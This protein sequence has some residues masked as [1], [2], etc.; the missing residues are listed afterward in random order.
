M[1]IL[2]T[3]AW[4][5]AFALCAIAA[6]RTAPLAAPVPSSVVDFASPAAII[7]LKDKLTPYHAPGA[8]ETDGSRWYMLTALN[9]S[10]R[11][12]TRIFV[13]GQPPNAIMRFWPLPARPSVLQV[14]ASDSQVIVEEAR[15]HGRHVYRVTIPPAST[16]T[17]AVRLA[18]A[19]T[20]PSVL[21]WTEPAIVAH[22]RQLAVFVA[23]VA[24]MIAAA[25][26]IMLGLAVMTGHAAPFW[27]ALLL[28]AIF[29][30]R[31]AVTGTFDAGW[32]TRGG[33]FGLEVALAGL[34]FVVGLRLTDFIVPIET[35]WPGRRA[36]FSRGL[37]ALTI[38]SILS[39]LGVP[40]AM[41]L[42]DAMIVLGSIGVT[43][44]F[45][46]CGRRGNQ[47]ARV[48]APSAGVF[49]LVALG[50]TAVAFG[51]FA[52][53][54][55]APAIVGGFMAAGAV[56]LALAVA[57]GE[58]IAIL[59]ASRYGLERE[60]TPRPP[61]DTGTTDLKAIG[62]SHQGVF[63]LDFLAETVRLS[64]EAAM[65]TGISAMPLILPHATWIERIHPDD[66][67]TYREAIDDYRSHPGIAFRIEF[68]ALNDA[69]RHVWFELRAT[70]LGEGIRAER[71]LGLIADVTSRKEAD[72]SPVERETRDVLTGLGNRAALVDTLERLGA[73]LSSTIVAL[74]DMDRFKTVH[75][76]LGDQ[77]S[78]AVLAGMAQRLVHHF[79]KAAEIFRGGGDTFT[80]VFS[81]NGLTTAAIGGDLM[82]A[83]AA[84]FE[85]G[86]RNVFVTA[87]AGLAA[88]KDARD[89]FELLKNAELALLQAKRQGGACA[90]SYTPALESTAPGDAVALEADLRQAL[91]QQ[92]LDVYYQPIVRLSDGTLAGFEAL[93]RWHHPEKGLIEPSNFIAHSEQTGL[94]KAIGKLALERTAEDLAQWQRFFPLEPPLFASVNLS[95]RQL[96]DAEFE[97]ELKQVMNTHKIRPGTLKLEITESAVATGSDT[98]KIL[99]RLRKAGASLAIDDFGT[100]VSNFQQLKEIPFD[101]VKLDRSFLGRHG[102]THQDAEG[103]VILGSIVNLAHDLERDVVIEGVETQD[104]ADWLRGIGAEYGQG[105]YF[106]AP[107]PRTEALDFIARHYRIE[108]GQA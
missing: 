1:S 30:L 108:T 47:A 2:R 25:M 6:W 62:A 84:P 23:A 32:V 107:L 17:L 41:I 90:R 39:Y 91:D 81:G 98:S 40:G 87:S 44:Y 54:Q 63:E 21:A 49:A 51:M 57:A 43:L 72:S 37:I 89:P 22:N 16:V 93:M 60:E 24:G 92:Q 48:A 52:N 18:N 76:S 75:A 4:T 12:A 96:L 97:S 5:L 13:A 56:L 86:G 99:A 38:L 46:A 15:A 3:F 104:E 85:Q 74:L 106:S 83:C 34:A 94:I 102:G 9:N 64:R 71:C 79:G 8:P 20:P 27:A 42:V 105:F 67:A 80:L 7:E 53:N 69:G 45:L 95:R 100:G 68:R 73:R 55:A 31:L 28:V 11:P 101:T 59:P 10:V 70:M 29:V 19:D 82:D 14:A 61:G 35:L 77:G 36:W 58:G 50:A 65:L 26:A 66:R 78:D 103:S 33:P 88:G